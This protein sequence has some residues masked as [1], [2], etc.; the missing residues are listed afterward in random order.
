MMEFPEQYL[1]HFSCAHRRLIPGALALAAVS[2]LA[3]CGSN[4]R[5]TTTPITGTGPGPQPS[6][7]AIVLSTPSASEPGIATVIDYSGDTVMAT[8]PIGPAPSTFAVNSGGSEAWSLDA[9]GT[10]ANI[11]FST[12]L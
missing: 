6:A 5:P 1:P 12:S 8:A 4:Y 10:L 7:T 2:V 9:D 11:P 3:G